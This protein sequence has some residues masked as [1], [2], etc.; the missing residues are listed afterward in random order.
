MRAVQVL[1]RNTFTCA[2]RA[3]SGRVAFR[4]GVDCVN[5]V[6]RSRS[7]ADS[8]FTSKGIRLADGAN[9]TWLSKS[10]TIHLAE[11]LPVQRC[12]QRASRSR[13][14]SQRTKGGGSCARE[15]RR[16]RG[17]AGDGSRPDR[18]LSRMRSGVMTFGRSYRQ[19]P[20][21]EEEY[22]EVAGGG[23]SGAAESHSAVGR[24]RVQ[25]AAFGVRSADCDPG[26]CKVRGASAGLGH[27]AAPACAVIKASRPR[28]RLGGIVIVSTATGTQPSRTTR[29]SRASCWPYYFSVAQG[30]LSPALHDWVVLSC[31]RQHLSGC[32]SQGDFSAAARLY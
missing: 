18:R 32:V 20:P 1:T 13:L 8:C 14:Q 27:R 4:F 12:G 5:Y 6:F 21:L 11:L 28:R 10:N 3:K 15:R 26:K 9:Q 7:I 19:R 24:I 31:H 16:V 25:T 23:P 22:L 17:A 30:R 2:P 29:A